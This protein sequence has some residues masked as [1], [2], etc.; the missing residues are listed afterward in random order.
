MLLL[1]TFSGIFLWTLSEYLLHRFLG[2]VH[3]GRNFF[4]KEHVRHHS[5]PHYF[6]PVYKKGVLAFA[7]SLALF[8]SLAFLIGI[9]RSFFFT[10]GYTGM[11]LVYELTHYRYHASEPVPFFINFRKHHFYHHYHNPM[12]NH[13]VTSRFWDRVF[14]T[15]IPIVDP[16]KVPKKMAPQWLIAVEEQTLRPEYQQHF[17]LTGR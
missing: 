13:G 4:K 14:G 1:C 12:V 10:A 9:D 5:T 15:Y 6:A 8:V 2:H 3:K 7:V 16:V 11:Y 17:K